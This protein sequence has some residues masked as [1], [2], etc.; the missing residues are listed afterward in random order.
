MAERSESDP[1]NLTNGDPAE[2]D[3]PMDGSPA[4]EGLVPNRRERRRAG[5]TQPQAGRGQPVKPRGA[6][7]HQR[8]YTNRKHG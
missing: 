5:K 6:A 1:D 3:G 2:A 7:V 4:S 8:S